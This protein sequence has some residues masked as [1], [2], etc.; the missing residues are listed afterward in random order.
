MYD[1]IKGSAVCK[2][3]AVINISTKDNSKKFTEEVFIG[4]QLTEN[5]MSM[6][7]FEVDNMME[8]LGKAIKN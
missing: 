4:F 1:D 3:I 8:Q 6:S 2:A 7:G 5:G